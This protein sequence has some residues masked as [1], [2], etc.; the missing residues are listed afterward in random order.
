LCRTDSIEYQ[1]ATKEGERASQEAN[2]H[3]K[4]GI[5]NKIKSLDA[6]KFVLFR[7]GS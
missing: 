5:N 7:I 1:I 6:R 4:E 2:G 3:W